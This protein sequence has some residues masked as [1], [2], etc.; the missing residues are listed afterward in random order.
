MY[1]EIWCFAVACL[2]CR[3]VKQFLIVLVRNSVKP[4]TNYTQ[5]V[6]RIRLRPVVPE[7]QPEDLETLDP[8]QFETNLSLGKYRDEPGLFDDSL[9]KLLDDIQPENGGQ[10]N[11]PDAPSQIRQ[12]P[13]EDP[14]QHQFLR[15]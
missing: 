5:C 6:H 7:H 15:Q 11:L 4:G 8:S 2:S 10:S 13:L 3:H 14:Q 1:G 9:P 12:Y